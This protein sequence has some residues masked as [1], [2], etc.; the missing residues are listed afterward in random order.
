MRFALMKMKA[1]LSHI[2]Y[3]FE[4]QLCEETPIPLQ[5]DPKALLYLPAGDVPLI[6][7]RLNE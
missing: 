2:L 7:N 3:N 4:V 1:D 5:V 6:F